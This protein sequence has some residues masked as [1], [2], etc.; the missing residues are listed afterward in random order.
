MKVHNLKIREKPTTI[1]NKTGEEY[2]R[3][4]FLQ[5][6]KNRGIS[7]PSI[8]SLINQI[9]SKSK[10]KPH[11]EDETGEDESVEEQGFKNKYRRSYN[12]ENRYSY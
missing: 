4:K 12:S 6:Y 7:K 3:A 10:E 9:Q 11:I 1:I 2:D 8:P 5:R